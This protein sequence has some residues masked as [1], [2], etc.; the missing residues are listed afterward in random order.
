M[1]SLCWMPFLYNKTLHGEWNAYIAW[2][3]FFYRNGDEN[4]ETRF[5]SH[6]YDYAA[7]H[8]IVECVDLLTIDIPTKSCIIYVIHN[9]GC[10]RRVWETTTLYS[11]G[12]FLV[13][14]SLQ[15]LHRNYNDTTNIMFLRC[16]PFL[17]LVKQG[18]NSNLTFDE[19]NS[20]I[21]FM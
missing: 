8:S 2:F 12:S 5:N 10:G 19:Y 11:I 16:P 18:N 21:L 9:S 17:S 7:L 1:Q 3:R 13:V 6:N 20:D 4:N 15:F 14:T